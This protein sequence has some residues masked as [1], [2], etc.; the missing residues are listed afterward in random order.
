[1]SAS[2]QRE[3]ISKKGQLRAALPQRNQVVRAPRQ[4][5]GVVRKR[6]RVFLQGE[7]A[8]T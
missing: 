5:R 6:F 3:R 4:V 1:M 8:E 2:A 7:E